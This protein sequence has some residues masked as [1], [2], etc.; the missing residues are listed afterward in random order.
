MEKRRPNQKI[1]RV[2]PSRSIKRRALVPGRRGAQVQ[3]NKRLMVGRDQAHQ[4]QMTRKRGWVPIRRP[5][6][7][8][9][10]VYQ[11]CGN[12]YYRVEMVNIGYITLFIHKMPSTEGE[13]KSAS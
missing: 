12:V 5:M 10:I 7:N 13:G 9:H 4:A 6:A 2:V 11:K 1:L 8:G 3:E